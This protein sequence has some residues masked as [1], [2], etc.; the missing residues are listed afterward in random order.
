MTSRAGPSESSHGASSAFKLAG[1]P[2]VHQFCSGDAWPLRRS[3]RCHFSAPPGLFL[4][5]S[6]S[7]P[8]SVRTGVS[9]WCGP[10]LG[11]CAPTSTFLS[12]G[13]RIFQDPL[14]PPPAVPSSAHSS[15]RGC[16]W[17][18]RQRYSSISAE[19]FVREAGK[20]E[21]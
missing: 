19:I 6:A 12:F 5:L 16:I 15:V 18:Q 11:A 13:C 21:L 1:H 7:P 2:S 4:L 20:V 14:P 17:Q 10:R 3:H 9:I 8:R